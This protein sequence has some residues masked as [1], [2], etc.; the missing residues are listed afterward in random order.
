[1]FNQL[2]SSHPADKT[3]RINDRTVNYRE[4]HRDKGHQL[5]IIIG[6]HGYGSSERQLET[7]VPLTIEQPYIYVAPRAFEAVDNG[8]YGWYPVSVKH[9]TF[10]INTTAIAPALDDVATIIKELV[11]IYNADPAQVFVVG[12]SMGGSVSMMLA[13]T[14]PNIAT[15]FVAMAG[16]YDPAILTQLAPDEYLR[17]VP[18]FVGHGTLDNLISTSDIQSATEFMKSHDML[19]TLKQYRIPHVVGAQEREDV[20]AWLNKLLA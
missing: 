13:L 19:V 9:N 2:K 6:L 17:G 18:L 8:G 16:I 5:P 10:N 20:S 15:A 14:H 11:A 3:L 7:L 12:Y 4:I 1:M